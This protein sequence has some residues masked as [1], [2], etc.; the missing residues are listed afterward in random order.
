MRPI[1]AVAAPFAVAGASQ[2]QTI[3]GSMNLGV[4]NLQNEEEN[5]TFN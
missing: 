1:D 2:A 3:G 4:R 5:R